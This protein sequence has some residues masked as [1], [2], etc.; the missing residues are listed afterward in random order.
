[1]A[2]GKNITLYTLN[3]NSNV[4][5][6]LTFMV[7]SKPISEGSSQ[8]LIKSIS[9][10]IDGRT[11]SALS[12][13][14]SV[15]E[16]GNSSYKI[17]N[18]LNISSAITGF[19]DPYSKN[20][21]AIGFIDQDGNT[22][23]L[24]S[25]G[26]A[27]TAYLGMGIKS[28]DGKFNNL[29]F[30]NEERFFKEFNATTTTAIQGTS[31]ADKFSGTEDSD[32]IYL[33]EGNDA[34]NGFAGNDTIFGGAGNDTLMGGVGND[35]IDGGDGAADLV[36]FYDHISA[37]TPT[38]DAS[39]LRFTI[40]HKGHPNY[41]DGTDQ[42]SNVEKFSFTDSG[43]SGKN[44]LIVNIYANGNT[45]KTING[46]TSQDWLY[47]GSGNDTLDGKGGVDTMAGGAGD[48]TYYVDKSEDV[49]IEATDA[50][51][52]TVNSSV[53]YA[54]SANLEKL[55]L[56]GSGNILATGNSSN[57]VL[58]GNSGNN[59]ID[60]GLG[61]DT[62]DGGKGNDTYVVD[63]I[64]DVIKELGGEG[65]DTV[66]SSVNYTLADNLENLTLLGSSDLS[67][68]GNGLNNVI[69]GN[70]GNNSING[71]LGADTLTG[72][73][74]ID[75]FIFNDANFSSPQNLDT[76]TDFQSGLDKIELL[77]NISSTNNV[78]LSSSF[79]GVP[80][81]ITFSANKL[82]IDT[83]GDKVADFQLVLTG[84]TA[85][86][87]SD[88]IVPS[89]NQGGSS[90]GVVGGADTQ[91]GGAGDDKYSVDN[92]ADVIIE[93][94]NAG[95]DTVDSTV[96][97]TL[98]DNLENLNLTG[99]ANIS[100]TGNALANY[101]V[102]NRANNTI[103]GGAGAD[104]MLG[105]QGNDVYY[106]DTYSYDVNS[107]DSHQ[108]PNG[109]V[110]REDESRGTDT[111]LY[112]AKSTFYELPAN[113]ENFT[114]MGTG[115]VSLTANNLNNVIIGGSGAD[116]L[117]GGLGRDTLTGGQGND[118]FSY[119]DVA[120]ST[121]NNQDTITDFQSGADKIL[122]LFSQSSFNSVN[123]V[124]SLSGVAGEMVFKDTML[125]IDINGDKTEDFKITLVGVTQFQ[126]TDVQ[127]TIFG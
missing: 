81:Q 114:M 19:I 73:A 15:F 67:A 51:T 119:N 13:T 52:D 8:Y 79:T 43:N 12:S 63:N 96:S 109:D 55:I 82:S 7:D 115:K 47:S 36:R 120:E 124:S 101:I 49:I 87:A 61:L 117:L 126:A 72:G 23:C 5:G 112:F 92:T 78:A 74:G 62:L 105:G 25:S 53:N 42:I 26:S 85:V 57:N 111:I 59:T 86:S 38:Y 29:M 68:T 113:V 14:N 46:S 60:G 93:A 10:Q 110:V 77:F 37:Y 54:L 3:F 18:K 40:V 34:L 84:V 35:S 41:Q 127:L 98:G 100:G 107:S 45:A 56:T 17:T 99:T 123:L 11:I 64:G 1:M 97:Y 50:G 44:A 4:K 75:R 89:L 102:G 88:I 21:D 66:N 94:V 69:I 80:G 16:I 71:G 27:V 24:A 22:Y 32:L 108:S 83:N 104:T 58:T 125:A 76:I 28:K 95:V 31:Q 121:P 116:T 118:R 39:S 30:I 2:V 20:K 90:G 122:L 9:G 103:D 91:K 6:T 48:D 33:L 70:T 65:T 106:V